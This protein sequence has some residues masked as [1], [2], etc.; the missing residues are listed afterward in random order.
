MTTCAQLCLYFETFSIS[1]LVAV[2]PIPVLF[3]EGGAASLVR[4]LLA[5]VLRLDVV[6][7]ELLVL[8]PRPLVPLHRQVRVRIGGVQVLE[9]TIRQRVDSSAHI[10]P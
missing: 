9:N 6:E 2:I 4:L 7:A 5:V 10:K 1:R 3:A 8:L